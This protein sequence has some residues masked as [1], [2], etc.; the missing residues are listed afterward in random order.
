MLIVALIMPII[1][2][3]KKKKEKLKNMENLYK[4]LSRIVCTF[5]KT[6]V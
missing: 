5:S 2:K 6:L 1:F 4:T 3:K